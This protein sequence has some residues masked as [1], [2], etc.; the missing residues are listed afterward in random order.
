[1]FKLSILKSKMWYIVNVVLFLVSILLFCYVFVFDFDVIDSNKRYVVA[2]KSKDNHN[3]NQIDGVLYKQSSVATTDD[4]INQEFKF[5]NENN[6]LKHFNSSDSSLYL[7]VAGLGLDKSLLK[8]ALDLPN[9]VSLGVSAYTDDIDTLLYDD[10]SE[11]RDILINIP[12]QPS[13]GD[14][15]HLSISSKKTT[16]DNLSGLYSILES[17]VRYIGVYTDVHDDIQSSYLLY[18]TLKHQNILLYNILDSED[19][20]SNNVINPTLIID[21]SHSINDIKLSLYDLD[22]NLRVSQQPFKVIVMLANPSQVS[23]DI[24]SSWLKNN[25]NFRLLPLSASINK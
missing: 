21:G 9:E 5:D 17:S 20:T 18:D 14:M 25:N 2:V 24:L 15:G 22:Y 4:D 16:K 11:D 13:L 1:M 10:Y 8:K 6:K 23:I 12:I 7:M 19:V 3:L